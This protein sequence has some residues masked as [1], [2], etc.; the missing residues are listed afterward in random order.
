M[1]FT[2]KHGLIIKASPSKVYDAVTNPDHLNNWWTLKCTGKPTIGGHY[3]LYFAPEYDW[4]AE[5]TKAENGHAFEL[6]MK[7]TMSD[8]QPTSFGFKLSAKDSHTRVSFYHKGWQT[9]G[10]HFEHTSYSWALLLKGLKDYIEKDIIL[11]FE[12]RA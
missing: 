3:N 7:E 2:I 12:A 1:N 4:S 9:D 6:K 8:W 10:N 11:P 5:V